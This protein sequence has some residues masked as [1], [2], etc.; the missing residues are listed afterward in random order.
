[1]ANSS[2]E[3]SGSEEEIPQQ[4][5]V[6]DKGKVVKRKSV[7]PPRAPKKKAKS[8]SADEVD[9]DI[10]SAHGQPE[11]ELVTDSLTMFTDGN[12]K[13]G[14]RGRER[15][16]AAE[17]SDQEEYKTPKLTI[18]SSTASNGHLT[19]SRP[20]ASQNLVTEVWITYHRYANDLTL[21]C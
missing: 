1:M 21:H 9:D 2:D 4:P 16:T 11:D 14:G 6:A 5:R 13:K 7:K 19:S 18:F 3:Y 15:N 17:M 8:E 10:P 20:T 12:P